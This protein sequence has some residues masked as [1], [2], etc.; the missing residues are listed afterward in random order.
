MTDDAL[1]S[2]ARWHATVTYRTNAGP[3]QGDKKVVVPP[4]PSTLPG[5]FEN[6]EAR[7]SARGPHSSAVSTANAPVRRL[8]LSGRPT[9]G[10]QQ[11]PLLRD[12]RAPNHLCAAP[13]G[14]VP[15]MGTV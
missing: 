15:S 8:V 2:L 5:Q 4:W 10:A 13:S 11:R 7:A 6:F 3:L 9:T 14:T 12:T 1:S